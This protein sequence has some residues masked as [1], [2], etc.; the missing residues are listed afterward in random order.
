MWVIAV[1]HLHI[2]SV[3]NLS[4]FLS[5]LGSF[6]LLVFLSPIVLLPWTPTTALNPLSGGGKA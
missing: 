5:F 2:F 4:S 3:M 1:T 6:S